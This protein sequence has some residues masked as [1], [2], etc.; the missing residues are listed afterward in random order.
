[1]AAL[2][3]PGA[4]R[5]QQSR[6]VRRVAYVWIFKEGPSAPY[7][8]AFRERMRELGWIEGQNIV[9]DPRDANGN[10]ERLDAIMREL[11]E[12][13]YDVITTACTPEAKSAVKFTSTIPIVMAATGDAVAAGLAASLARPGG[14]VTG[15]SAMLLEQSAKRLEI[16]KEAFPKVAI[17]TVLWNPG[18]PDNRPEVKAMQAAAQSL[19]IRLD[20]TEV[21]SPGEL[22]DVLDVLP[23]SGTQAILNTGDPL[24]VSQAPR[25][26]AYANRHRLPTLFE[27]RVFVDQGALMSYGPDFPALHRHAADYVDKILRGAK[28]ADMPIEQPTRFQLVVNLRTAKA[29]GFSIPQSLLVRADDVIA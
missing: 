26:I 16:L 20:S 22:G 12:S 13:K 18:R 11:V 1:L 10:P 7:Y 27:S 23:T 21:R 6:S 28:P 8:E 4:A 2:L 5:A 9:I 14:N 17:A 29:L 15:I 24:V 3:G 19:G 25:I